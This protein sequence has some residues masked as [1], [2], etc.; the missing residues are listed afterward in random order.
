[1]ALFR[2]AGFR[3][4]RTTKPLERQSRPTEAEL[5]V[6]ENVAEAASRNGVRVYVTVMIPDR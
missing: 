5:G 2:A 6:L 1:M 3:S 4:V